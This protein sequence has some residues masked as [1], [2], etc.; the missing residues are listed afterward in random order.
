MVRDITNIIKSQQKLSD[1]MYQ[2]A[3]EQN[4]SHEQMTPL[5]II[6]ANSKILI[7]RFKELQKYLDELFDIK[8]NQQLKQE[9]AARN[10]ETIKII[11]AIEQSGQ[12]MWYYNQNQI[13]R[14]KI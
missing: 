3:I 12:G 6:L 2:D 10:E 1:D 8:K 9:V 7:K 11:Q 13:Q 14:M 5:N 4:Y